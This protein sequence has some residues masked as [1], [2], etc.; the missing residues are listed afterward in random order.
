MVTSSKITRLIIIPINFN[1]LSNID[2][3]VNMDADNDLKHGKVNI[4]RGGG[5]KF[6]LDILPGFKV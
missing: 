4:L 1:K 3:Q 2:F 6:V 5:G